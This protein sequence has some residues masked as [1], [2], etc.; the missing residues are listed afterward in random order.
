[1]T[2]YVNGPGF[3]PK[4]RLQLISP[5]EKELTTGT[6]PQIALENKV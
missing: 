2:L 5:A 1:M 6:K 4:R 3:D